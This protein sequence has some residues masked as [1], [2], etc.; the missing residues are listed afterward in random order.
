MNENAQ[1]PAF[2]VRHDASVRHDAPW[3]ALPAEVVLDHVGGVPGGRSARTYS[4]QKKQIFSETAHAEIGNV[5]IIWMGMLN[6][7]SSNTSAAYPQFFMSS[8]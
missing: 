6:A 5:P 3:H 4:F 8:P 7:V 1:R 2:E